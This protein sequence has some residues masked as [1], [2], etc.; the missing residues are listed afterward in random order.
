MTVPATL[1]S[2]RFRRCY[3]MAHTD[4]QEWGAYDGSRRGELLHLAIDRISREGA[5]VTCTIFTRSKSKHHFA[6]ST[7]RVSH[8]HL[9]YFLLF[10]SH[11]TCYCVPRARG[12]QTKLT[13]TDR[14][15]EHIGTVLMTRNIW[16]GGAP[17]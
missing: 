9:H 15:A 4:A 10:S 6:H 1:G 14:Q 7:A 11:A 12:I 17:Q 3:G 5:E 16:L 13:S 2:N 8:Y